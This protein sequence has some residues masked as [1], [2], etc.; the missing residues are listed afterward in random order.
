[1]SKKA[2]SHKTR[3]TAIALLSQGQTAREVADK[4]QLHLDTILTLKKNHKDDII[5]SRNRLLSEA[6]KRHLDL[7]ST[8]DESIREVIRD[9]TSKHF[10]QICKL[11]CETSGLLS[12]GPDSLNAFFY[13][14]T[15]EPEHFIELYKEQRRLWTTFTPEQQAKVSEEMDKMRESTASTTAPSPDSEKPEDK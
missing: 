11:V 8:M 14:T 10:S 2:I 12:H 5:V 13:R 15:S 7:I 6:R 9:P 4:T 1:M 3:Q